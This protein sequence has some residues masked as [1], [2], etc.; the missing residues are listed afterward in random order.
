MKRLLVI[1]MCFPLTDLNAQCE[2][3][4]QDA[5]RVLKQ[6]LL[7][8]LSM[9]FACS[10]PFEMPKDSFIKVYGNNLEA[11]PDG[12]IHL[13]NGGFAVYGS[14]QRNLPEDNYTESSFIPFIVLTDENGNELL[15]R[16]IPFHDFQY[17]NNQAS[18]VLWK[19]DYGRVWSMIELNNGN[20]MAGILLA[21][22]NP[23]NPGGTHLSYHYI[24]LDQNLNIESFQSFNDYDNPIVYYT[25]HPLLYQ[26]PG[27]DDV[28][29]LMR[30]STVL[31]GV[32]EYHST[33][34]YAIYR[35]SMD[36]E[37]EWVKSFD[38]ATLRYANDLTFDE[39]G[40]IIVM[41]YDYNDDCI[42]SFADVIELESRKVIDSKALTEFDDW[43]VPISLNPTS[44]GYVIQNFTIG[45][46]LN[47]C[48]RYDPE[49]PDN[50]LE[51]SGSLIFLSDQLEF[52]N[53]VDVIDG[54]SGWNLKTLIKTSDGGF[55]LG[56]IQNIT[57]LD[58]IARTVLIKTNYDG[59]VQWIYEEPRSILL[60]GLAETDDGGIVFIVSKGLTSISNKW[61]LI[62]LDA[63]GKLY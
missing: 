49:D 13:K 60:E 42:Y 54:I 21:A 19:V 38:H 57:D 16:E 2:K 37:I 23:F 50:A 28:L 62:K 55:A 9:L 40:N 51:A 26:I 27:N 7:A 8:T 47:L 10:D 45:D 48:R 3:K 33:R 25:S 24:I 15:S 17:E 44:N 43:N 34:H 22:P 14:V 61:A 36:G 29:V 56:Y 31:E 63:N 18:F 4:L 46:S 20:F 1:M 11:S 52:Q 6:F 41:G 58:P 5:Q 53:E 39:N 32:T 35:I 30:S 12:F 59:Q